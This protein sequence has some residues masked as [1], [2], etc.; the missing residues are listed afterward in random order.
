[1]LPVMV[2]FK[3]NE[4]PHHSRNRSIWRQIS[5]NVYFNN[6]DPYAYIVVEHYER[7]RLTWSVI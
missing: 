1:M 3:I 2:N 4:L 6:Y 7:A 5:T